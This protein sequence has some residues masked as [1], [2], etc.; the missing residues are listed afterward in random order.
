MFITEYLLQ[1]G[2]EEFVKDCKRKKVGGGGG[3]VRGGGRAASQPGR[4]VREF[5]NVYRRILLSC[6]GTSTTTR[7]MK[8]SPRMVSVDHARPAVGRLSRDPALFCSP[9]L[10]C[11]LQGAPRERS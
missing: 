6:A 9:R 1:N 11:P 7:T 4:S 3:G 8:T 5:T 10:L 2:S